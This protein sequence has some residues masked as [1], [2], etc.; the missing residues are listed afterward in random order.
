MLS[1]ISPTVKKY[2]V[3]PV[4]DIINQ[5]YLENHSISV[6]LF[7]FK[8]YHIMQILEIFLRRSLFKYQED[9]KLK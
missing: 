2:R 6:L 4:K 9:D 3:I 1:F 5:L 8:K 7:R